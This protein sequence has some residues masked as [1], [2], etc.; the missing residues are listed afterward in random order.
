ME[1]G[2]ESA[3]GIGGR[4]PV[5]PLT[6]QKRVAMEARAGRQLN[7]RYGPRREGRAD[8]CDQLV[9]HAVIKAYPD[10]LC[11]AQKHTLICER[12]ATL[13]PLA[14]LR[15]RRLEKKKTPDELREILRVFIKRNGLKI[16]PWARQAGVDK[17]SIYNFLNGYSNALDAATY[18]KLANAAASPIW[19][20]NGDAPTTQ[21]ETA[22]FVTGAV[23]A[24]RF[25]DT[26]ERERSEWYPVD[27]PIPE[28][29]RGKARALEVHGPSMNVEYP[30]GSV[31]VWVPSSDVRAPE[32]GDHVIAISRRV[33]GKVEATIKEYRVA[34]ERVWLCPKSDHPAHQTP[35]ALDEL[36]EEIE[37]V[38]V[39]GLVAG[40]YR[41]RIL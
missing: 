39:A 11:K 10:M 5:V 35:V 31:V 34:D 41:P 22:V 24:G 8:L 26:I 25:I 17:N 23:E 37:A 14:T 36:P 15:V 19:A 21:S 2:F 6:P 12:P 4:V 13:R 30:D 27:I 1:I 29:F 7:L 28:R 33:D 20:L 9:N 38:E 18:I 3:K 40:G 16:A 32:N